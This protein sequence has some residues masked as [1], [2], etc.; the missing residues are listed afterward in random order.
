MGVYT[1]NQQA[2]ALKMMWCLSKSMV[3]MY[4]LDKSTAMPA[5]VVKCTAL[6]S[7]CEEIPKDKK[8]G[9]LFASQLTKQPS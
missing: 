4:K 6:V 3:A 2:I 7:S 5:W 1:C 8:P 9:V